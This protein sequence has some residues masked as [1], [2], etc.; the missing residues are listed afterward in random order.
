MYLLSVTCEPLRVDWLSGELWEAGTLGIRE[1]LGSN[2]FITLEAVFEVSGAGDPLLEQFGSLQ[3]TWRRLPEHDWVQDTQQAWP[4]R[5]I[6]R[7]LF[8]AAPWCSDPTPAGRER[9]T[10]SP[11]V[12]CGTGEH[13]CT[14]L[15]LEALEIVT[16]P[17]VSV[18]DVGTGSGLLAIAA[19]KLGAGIAVGLDIDLGALSAAREN[20]ALNGL[21]P[22]LVAGSAECLIPEAADV[23]VANINAS[24]L[25]SLADDLL[26]TL[27]PGGTLVLTGFPEEESSVIEAMFPP[28]STAK[29]DGWSC[30]T[31]RPSFD[32]S[33]VSSSNRRSR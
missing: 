29:R 20:F 11:G 25:L 6:G 17:G 19:L 31:Y 16:S 28:W 18:I 10:H 12:A 3:P 4:G 8:L 24:V 23:I 1:V 21:H 9:I 27:K 2:G 7:R 30:I 13:P 15:A 32:A 26:S 5:A 14:Q 22:A 33:V